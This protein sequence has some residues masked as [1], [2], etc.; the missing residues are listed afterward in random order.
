MKT[1]FH[2]T[3]NNIERTN[4]THNSDCKLLSRG[5]CVII[6]THDKT[7]YL[8]IIQYFWSDSTLEKEDVKASINWF[9]RASDVKAELKDHLLKQVRKEERQRGKLNSGDNQNS[10][11]Q[12]KKRGRPWW[13]EKL[14]QQV[15]R[16]S[17]KESIEGKESQ[18]SRSTSPK[19]TSKTR[20]KKETSNESDLKIPTNEKLSPTKNPSILRALDQSA[21]ELYSKELITD[22]DFLDNPNAVYASKHHDT[23]SVA[24]IDDRCDVLNPTQ[25]FAY[26]KRCQLMEQGLCDDSR[27]LLA[28]TR[29]NTDSDIVPSDLVSLK[30]N[31]MLQFGRQ[32]SNQSKIPSDFED[33]IESSVIDADEIKEMEVQKV[34]PRPVENGYDSSVSLVYFCPGMWDVSEKRIKRELDYKRLL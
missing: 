5:D 1:P 12:K 15:T 28:G 20:I 21:K 10:E 19:S 24:S 14:K 2:W 31:F 17:S 32:K 34:Q 30:T 27:F 18:R 23:I 4:T 11:T 22:Q 7:P 16:Q 13:K 26:I 29:K 6:K 9:Y 33:S 8:A 3:F 25:Y